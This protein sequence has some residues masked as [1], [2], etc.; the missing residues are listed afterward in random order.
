M[1]ELDK[2]RSEV[3]VPAEWTYASAPESRDVVHIADRYGYF[4]IGRAHV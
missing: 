1:A 3:D 4:E 2:P